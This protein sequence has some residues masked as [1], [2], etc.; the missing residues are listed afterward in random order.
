M[1][2]KLLL[3]RELAGCLGGIEV[4]LMSGEEASVQR[5]FGQSIYGD[6]LPLVSTGVVQSMLADMQP[7]CLYILRGIL[8]LSYAVVRL[9][10]HRFLCAG[11]CMSVEFS[12]SR[13]RTQLRPFRLS[14]STTERVV[15]YCRWQPVLTPEVLHRFGV[16]LCRHVL[17]MPEPIPYQSIDYRWYQLGQP[18]IPE[19][20]PAASHI[21]RVEQRYEASAALTQAVKQ[22]NL[23]LAYSFVQGFHPGMSEIVRNPN[24]LRNSQNICIILNTQLRYALEECRVHP[25][26]LDKVSG[27]IA[28]HIETL[29]SPEAAGKFC[30][31]IIRRYCELSVEREYQHLSRLSR[32]AVVYIKTRLSD[33]LTVKDTASALLVNANYLSGVFHRELGVTFIEFV[34]R[35]RVAQAAALLRHTNMQI[36]RI[37]AAVGYNN[38]SYFTRQFVRVWG[39]TPKEYRTKGVL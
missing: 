34:N 23:S 4:R 16:L 35:E 6:F 15:D 19:P 8:D 18:P 32:Q 29:K 21:H 30:A 3:A 36:Q 9:R 27:E 2:E 10:D 24:P 11:P 7:E 31:E 39:C 20:E 12:E 33:N 22:G 14:G 1:E 25:Y 13:V 26:L 5:F 17:G 38:T 28:L 37:A